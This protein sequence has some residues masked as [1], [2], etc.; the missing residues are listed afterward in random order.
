MKRTRRKKLAFELIPE[1][2]DVKKKLLSGPHQLLEQARRWHPH[3]NEA[4]IALAWRKEWKEDKDGLL[5]L[6]KCKKTS[7]LEKELHP[8]DFIVL[9]NREMWEAL[10]EEQRLALVDHELCHAQVTLDGTEAKRDDRGRIVYRV[11]KHDVEEF[12]EVVE[13]HGL[14][15]SDLEAFARSMVRGRKAPLLDDLDDGA[16]TLAVS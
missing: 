10:D 3:L 15:K 7:D 11:R 1:F 4:R 9:L 16:R 6:G 13:R 14:Y 12:R 5:V 2:A 8:F